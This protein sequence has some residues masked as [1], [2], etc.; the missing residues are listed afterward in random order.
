MASPVGEDGW[1]AY[2]DQQLREA[3]DLEG[4]IRVTESFRQAVSAEPGSVK[5]WTNYC[6]YFW[7]LYVD[8]QVGSDAGWPPDEQELG[9]AVFTLEDGLNLWQEGNTAVEYRVADSHEFW[10]RWVSVELDLLKQRGGENAV[11]RI[12]HIF[13]DRLQV[14]HATWETTSQMFSSFLSQ[15]SQN[16]YEFEMTDVTRKATTAKRLYAQREPHEL[17]L[18]QAVKS[19]D[20]AIVRQV[21]GEYL[22]WEIRQY[23]SKQHKDVE[24]NFKICLGL[25]SRALTGMLASDEATWLNYITLVSTSHTDI[26]TGNLRV[27]PALIPSMLDVLSRAARHVPWSGPVWAR[28]ILAAEETGLTFREVEGIKHAATSCGQLDRDGMTGVLDMYSAWCGYLKRTAMHPSANEEAVDVAEVGLSAALEDVE[29]WGKRKYGENYQGDPDYRLEKILVQFLTEKKDDIEGARAIWGRMSQIPLHA[30]SYD[31][32]LHWHQWEINVFTAMRSKTRSPTPVSSLRVPTH[33]TRV[34]TKALK[35]R[36][37][38]WPERIL[39][40]Y[41]KHCNDYESAETLRE[42]LDTIY[43]TRKGVTKRRE[44][45][46]AQAAQAQQAAYQEA[47]AAAVAAAKITGDVPM[48]EA[49]DGASPGSKRKRES[50]PTD[51]QGGSKRAKSEVAN[52]EEPKRDREHT[53]V[54]LWNLPIDATHNKIKQFFQGYG[55]IN[56]IDV[57]KRNDGA[58]A[59]VEFRQADDARAALIRDGK[60]FGDRAVQVTSAID[61]TLFVTNY[62]PDADDRFLRKLFKDCGEIHSIRFPSLR[63]NASRR[64]CYVT[65]YERA[66]AA[67]ALEFNDKVP[68]GSKFKLSVKISDPAHKQQRQGAMAEGRE[69]HVVNLPRNMSEEELKNLFSKAGKVFSV[70]FPHNNSEGN[71]GTAF[72]VMETKEQA[73]EAVKT[74]DQLIFGNR[75]IKVEVSVPPAQKKK[76]ATSYGDDGEKAGSPAPSQDRASPS[77]DGNSGSLRERKLDVLGIPETMNEARVRSLLAPTGQIVKLV[78][79]PKHGGAVVEYT[80]ASTAGKAALAIEGMEVEGHK[81]RIGTFGELFKQKAEHK[82]DRLVQQQP[83][84]QA[85]PDPKKMKKPTAAELMPPPRP[86]QRP[87]ALGSGKGRG[88]RLGAFAMTAKKDKPETNGT[89]GGGG[90]TTMTGTAVTAAPGPK[91]GNDFFRN[92]MLGNKQPAEGDATKKQP[93][94][95]EVKENGSTA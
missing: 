70:R 28:Y 83:G 23:K 48:T 11:R 50:T 55:D 30:N 71:G 91:K 8:S 52:G 38:D 22:D 41:E 26:R 84:S 10:Q 76:S 47:A 54:F 31:F 29:H 87:Q 95:V 57:Q 6:E 73:H 92:M 25:F 58:V 61:C 68:K 85:N 16:A 3:T 18:Q 36:T 17:K 46:A 39:Q 37:V 51:D 27:S 14:P 9:R 75:P 12:T 53:S 80:D 1:V 35:V 67:A 72:V 7:S 56:N 93:P 4:R 89:S 42:A 43:K 69:L 90:D 81:L 5:V 82:P 86:V 33:A 44:R 64:F 79:H 77:A 59:L 62:P 78:V 20:L 74:L 66:G 63:A 15:Y 13:R 19:G 45:E 2:I 60:Y 32:W 40:Q 24:D 21:M 34:F 94:E 49:T 88:I 65:F